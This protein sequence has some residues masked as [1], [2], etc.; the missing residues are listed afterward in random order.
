MVPFS[1]GWSSGIC[2]ILR[3]ASAACIPFWAQGFIESCHMGIARPKDL[4]AGQQIVRDHR[5]TAYFDTLTW[6]GFATTIR[7]DLSFQIVLRSIQAA[8]D[9]HECLEVG[10]KGHS[11]YVLSV[12]LLPTWTMESFQMNPRTCSHA[13]IRLRV[14]AERAQALD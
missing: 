13:R 11:F 1:F 9:P 8:F 5:V 4:Q 12:L 10:H 7:R 2:L 6:A 3:G 14:P